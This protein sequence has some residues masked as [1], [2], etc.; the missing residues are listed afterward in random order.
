V[1]NSP[2]PTR[3]SAFLDTVDLPGSAASRGEAKASSPCFAGSAAS[4]RKTCPDRTH[5]AYD[6]GAGVNETKSTD[7][8][9]LSDYLE[10]ETQFDILKA[11]KAI[12][13]HRIIS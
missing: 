3:C 5:H 11:R 9:K 8:Q 7:P 4:R 1:R 13:A 2:L 12:S 10:K 6:H